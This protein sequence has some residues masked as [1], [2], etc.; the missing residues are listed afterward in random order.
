MGEEGKDG[1]ERPGWEAAS[2]LDSQGRYVSIQG[3]GERVQHCP[4]G[5]EPAN[6]GVCLESRRGRSKTLAPTALLL[7]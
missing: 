2:H 4:C 3:L 1:E 7:E 6:F 5:D